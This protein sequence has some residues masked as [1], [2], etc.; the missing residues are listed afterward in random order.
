MQRELQGHYAKVANWYINDHTIVLGPD[1]R[2]HLFG[3][4]HAEPANPMEEKQFAHA[5][6]A[7]LNG[8]YVKDETGQVFKADEGAGK[9]QL[10]WAPHII[11]TDGWYYMFYCAGAFDPSAETDHQYQIKLA[12][13]KDLKSWTRLSPDTPFNPRHNSAPKTKHSLPLFIE[14]DGYDARDPF[15]L[16]V[17]AQWVMYY[18]TTTAHD[19]TGHHAVAYRTSTDLQH[20]SNRKFAYIDASTG[21]DGGPTESPFV[22]FRNG[23]YYL[24]VCANDP[25]ESTVVYQS[26]DPFNFVAGS[27][28]THLTEGLNYFP[29]HAAEIVDDLDGTQYITGAGW[30]LGGVFIAPLKWK[31]PF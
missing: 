10:I 8:P 19:E 4:T 25:Y 20:W 24:F 22:V 6:A 30:G 2:W 21:S 5:T 7:S 27:K 1:H 26:R 17:G 14:T 15:V 11:Q 18:A 16:K 9:E 3:I 31:S 23:E 29:M 12:V 28:L 13:S